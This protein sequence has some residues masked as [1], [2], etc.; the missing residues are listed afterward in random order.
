M[1]GDLPD[2]LLRCPRCGYD[3]RGEAGT[4]QTS[5][6]VSGRCPECGLAFEWRDL[7]S[8][9]KIRMA[10]WCVEYAGN[11]S[12][13]AVNSAKTLIRSL[14]PFDFWQQLELAH[15]IRP[16]RLV[17]YVALLTLSLYLILAGS[18]GIIVWHEV[19]AWSRTA[20]A[21]A[22]MWPLTLTWK[23]YLGLSLLPWRDVPLTGWG[24]TSV[25][26][27]QAYGQNIVVGL[28][29]MLGVHS[30]C[31]VAYV[32]LPVSRRVAKVRWIHIFRIVMYGMALI[33][34]IAVLEIVGTVLVAVGGGTWPPL[35]VDVMVGVMIATGFAFLPA[36]F[37]W[38]STAS[39]RYLRM[40]YPWAIGASVTVMGIL[41]SLS[42]LVLYGLVF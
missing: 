1:L 26:L 34:L 28:G 29:L 41:F 21:P 39:G 8:A 16:R 38:W 23:D 4:W 12:R 14:W 9:K 25:S 13:L 32:V 40:R 19:T 30:S 35:L 7:L 15:E 22:V 36:L 17:A 37:I 2:R 33:V 11:P 42:A 10:E 3:L 20:V 18:H 6:P 24:A 31:G 27:W 5:W